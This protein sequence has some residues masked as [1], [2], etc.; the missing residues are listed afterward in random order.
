MSKPV[1]VV[2]G[3]AIPFGAANV[4]TDVIIPA[5][6]MKIT[7][8]R[9]LGQGTFE[10]LRGKPGSIFDV[11]RNHGAP[12]LIAGENFGCGSSREHAVWGLLDMGVRA[13][14]APSF[15][16]IFAGNCAKNGLVAVTLRKPFIDRLMAIAAFATMTI[17]IE[18]LVLTTDQDDRFEFAM[19]T[20]RRR[21]LMD[22]LDEI[23]LIDIHRHAIDAWEERMSAKRPWS[24]RAALQP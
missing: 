18:E 2:A 5:R 3:I 6:W 4:D 16:D 9:G 21:C 23:A 10:A 20:F 17:D 13:I 19:D 11:E 15:A 24:R 22:G 7:T 1:R 12:I 14:V 8:R